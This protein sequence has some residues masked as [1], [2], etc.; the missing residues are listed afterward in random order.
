MHLHLAQYLK[1]NR[2]HILEHWITEAEVPSL[3]H[4]RCSNGSEGIIP[5]SYLSRA[6]EQVIT[7]LETGN[8]R[9]LNE[10]ETHLNDFLGHTCTCRDNTRVC[11]EIRDSGYVAFLSIFGE[12]WDTYHEFDEVDREYASLRIS[13]ILSEYFEEEIALCAMG[14]LRND[15]PYHSPNN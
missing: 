5:L 11:T 3:I 4:C 1:D 2:E 13:Q 14:K 6:I 12:D 10:S 8:F 15:C 9:K 7:K